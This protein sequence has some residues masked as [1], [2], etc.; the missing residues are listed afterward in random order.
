MNLCVHAPVE[1]RIIGNPPGYLQS[2]FHPEQ[3]VIEIAVL[4]HIP[5]ADAA[6]NL[7]FAISYHDAHIPGRTIEANK[8]FFRLSL[9]YIANRCISPAGLNK[10]LYLSSI[11][12]NMTGNSI[13]TKAVECIK[14]DAGYVAEYPLNTLPCDTTWFSGFCNE[15]S[16]ICSSVT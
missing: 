14:L 2:P 1:T 15:H 9:A 7:L 8:Y 3:G 16:V 6:S 5:P 13:S 4:N 10:S 12:I 11:I